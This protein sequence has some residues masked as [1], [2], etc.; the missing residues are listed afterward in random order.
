MNDKQIIENLIEAEKITRE[1]INK[2]RGGP[3]D[4]LAALV[5]TFHAL[6][7]VD[8]HDIECDYYEESI[9]SSLWTLKYHKK[10]LLITE[11]LMGRWGECPEYISPL[12]GEGARFINEHSRPL[13]EIIALL[14]F[15]HLATLDE[16]ERICALPISL[17]SDA[18][19]ERLDQQVLSSPLPGYDDMK[20][21]SEP[22]E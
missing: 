16:I 17:P 19:S 22:S 10:W 2:M 6:F 1:E 14:T 11:K 5:N 4:E 12:L 13:V 8:D 7:C 9:L 3:E 21:D 20:E 15:P 18:T